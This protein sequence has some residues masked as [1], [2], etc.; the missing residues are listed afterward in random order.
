[1]ELGAG[2]ATD[3]DRSFDKHPG[4]I[5]DT[6]MPGEDVGI[7]SSDRPNTGLLDFRNAMLRAVAGGTM[8]HF[9][10]I[11]GYYDG[12][13]SSQRQEMV[14]SM[15]NYD[16]LRD[17]FI[18]CIKQPTYNKFMEMGLMFGMITPGPETDILTIFDTEINGIPTTWID[19]KKEMEGFA[20]AKNEKFLSRGMIIRSMGNDPDE[21]A[22]EVDK[23]QE[24]EPDPIMAIP[25]NDE[26]GQDDDDENQEQ[27]NE[28]NDNAE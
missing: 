22:A 2:S 5:F 11:S 21:V 27:N 24:D 6:L 8:T 16:I 28:E 7:I 26:V 10:A 4:M 23:E 19:P 18:S 17:V 1:M 25:E 9:S 14:E 12:T 13:Y 20:L 3:Y 15:S